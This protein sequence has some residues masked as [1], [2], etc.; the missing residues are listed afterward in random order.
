MFGEGSWSSRR[1]PTQQ[2]RSRRTSSCGTYRARPEAALPWRTVEQV[3]LATL[4]YVWWWNNQRLHDELEYRT[5]FTVEQ[6]FYAALEEAQ[7][8]RASQRDR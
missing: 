3:E 4:E 2:R 7:P 1:S 6:A 5:P 8:A